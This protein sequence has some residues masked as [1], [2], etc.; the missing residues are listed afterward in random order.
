MSGQESPPVEA[1][2][3]LPLDNSFPVPTVTTAYRFGAFSCDFIR[4]LNLYMDGWIIFVYKPGSSLIMVLVR[5]WRPS[6]QRLEVHY[7]TKAF[8]VA[9]PYCCFRRI[10]T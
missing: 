2:A 9:G 5:G 7:W 1:R 6:P 8:K 4:S 3:F 10:A